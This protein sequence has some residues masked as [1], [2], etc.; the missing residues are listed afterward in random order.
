MV[1]QGCP[2]GGHLP[3]ILAPP[4]SSKATRVARMVREEEEEE[5]VFVITVLC[6]LWG[7]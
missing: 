1:D 4:F 5:G 3:T 2:V 7:K 6:F